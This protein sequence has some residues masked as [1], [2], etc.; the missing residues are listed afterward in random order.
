VKIAH[1]DD[2]LHK[3]LIFSGNL[4]WQTPELDEQF[5]KFCML[6]FRVR[7]PSMELEFVDIAFDVVQIL[8]Q[9]LRKPSG[10]VKPA[11]ED[12]LVRVEG[13]F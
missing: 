1:I 8:N 11:T 2:G 9:L 10:L 4:S 12:P 6:E 7:E 13:G 3:S 5:M